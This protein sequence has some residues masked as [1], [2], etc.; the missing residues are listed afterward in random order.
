[1]AGA[2]GGTRA[3]RARCYETE[4]SLFLQPIVEAL[5]QHAARTRAGADPGAGR[6]R[7]VPQLALLLPE[8]AATLGA[9][10]PSSGS[11]RRSSWPAVY[12]AVAE[13]PGPDG[14][15]AAG[16]RCCCSS[17]TCTSAGLATVELLHYLIRHAGRRPVLVVAT[18][19]TE[20]GAAGRRRA[21]PTSPS[22]LD[23]GPLPA[24]AV[25]ALATDSRPRRSLAES[26]VARTGGHALFVVETLRALAAGEAGVPASLTAAVLARV[27]RT[28]PDTEDLLRAAAVLGVDASN[29]TCWPGC[30]TSRAG[31]D[32]AP[33]RG[34][35]GRT[36]AGGRRPR[37]RVRQRPGPRGALREH[38]GADPAWPTTGAR[39]TCWRRG[40]RRWRRTRPR[41]VTPDV[42]RRAWLFAGEQAFRRL[43]AADADELLTARAG[44]R[45]A[46]PVTWRS[47]GRALLARGRV[48]ERRPTSP[49][50]STTTPVAV[51][52]ARQAGD[53]RLE[54]LALQ[55]RGGDPR[56]GAGTVDRRRDRG[57]APRRCGS[58]TSLGDREVEVALLAR[59]GVVACNRLRLRRRPGL[60][61]AGGRGR[62]GPAANDRRSRPR[63][64]GSRPRTPTSARSVQLETV[65]DELIPLLRDQGDARRLQWTVD[66]SAF[67]ALARGDWAAA[68][69]LLRGG[70]RDQR[71]SG[72]RAY[73]SWFLSHLGWAHRLRGDLGR[74]T[75]SR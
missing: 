58:P 40:R 24:D 37:L 70:A 38:P 48:R 18:V 1:M 75:A 66:E 19:R 14:V 54:M 2:T 52:V 43:A 27:A 42:P 13:L 23:V 62:P 44:R 17:T 12:E 4:R 67:P 45:R 46:P 25:A 26:I 35:P 50:R 7:R 65:L 73:E 33:L 22:V 20:E 61:P 3:Y 36:A 47:R 10:V 29:R 28:G 71:R 8:L 53:R 57:S 32:R 72:Y 56:V 21:A 39:P 6:R 31:G 55:A 9:P 15:R 5:G 60:R 11:A 34:G 74:G 69:E 59:L 41:S 63:W 30:S 68:T 64:T 49:P 16:V 51:S